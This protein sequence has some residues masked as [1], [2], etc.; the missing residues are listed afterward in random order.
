LFLRFQPREGEPLYLL[1]QR[2]R[3]V[4]EGGSW[5]IPGGAIR[6]GET[7]EVAAER[8]AEEE[9]WPVPPHRATGV[10]TQDCGGG[11]KFFVVTAIV[12]E[13]LPTYPAR[14][15]DATGWF[16]SED[17]R[18]LPLHPGFRAWL[19]TTGILS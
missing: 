2:S 6:D 7:P 15:T 12:D 13:A 16:A 11:W 9:I 1:T 10:I 5:A 17:M 19:V 3:W 4:D 18:T 14:Q 8:E